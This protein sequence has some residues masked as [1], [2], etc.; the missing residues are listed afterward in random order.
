VSG[1]ASTE[2]VAPL[3]FRL[4]AIVGLLVDGSARLARLS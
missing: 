3:T 4:M 2:W 1:S